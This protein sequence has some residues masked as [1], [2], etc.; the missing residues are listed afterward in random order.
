MAIINRT[1]RG[2]WYD[3]EAIPSW[4]LN[5]TV[6]RAA[7]RRAARDTKTDN[8]EDKQCK[9]SHDLYCQHT[10]RTRTTPKKLSMI[11]PSGWSFR[12][13]FETINSTCTNNPPL[14][15]Y[16][17]LD[18]AFF[19]TQTYTF[20]H[21]TITLPRSTGHSPTAD[22]DTIEFLAFDFR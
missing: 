14:R 16:V 21:S 15:Q 1:Y 17:W 13:Q 12:S 22:R 2:S 18:M 5:G 6:L 8:D 10:K 7:P 11:A 9:A 4:T 20:F 3:G 19:C